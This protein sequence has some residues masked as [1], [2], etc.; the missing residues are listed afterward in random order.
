MVL[1]CKWTGPAAATSLVL[2]LLLCSAS[3]VVAAKPGREDVPDI[4]SRRELM[5]DNFL[6]DR[7]KGQARMRLHNPVRREISLIHDAD[8]EGNACN[9]YTVFYDPDY[10]GSGRYRMY[11]HAW[12]IP[13]DGNQSHPLR[14]AY[15]ESDDGIHWKKPRLGLFE[16][17]GSKKNNIVDRL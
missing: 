2:G 12:H 4:G 17:D 7:L 8:W 6:V 9:Y 13:S 3:Q 14:I 11:Y 10:G 5:I 15:A 16:H 1:Q